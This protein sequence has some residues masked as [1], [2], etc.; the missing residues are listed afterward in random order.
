M[1]DKI[2]NIIN[3]ET[4]IGEDNLTYKKITYEI[5][6]P[7]KTY[8]KGIISGK[9]RGVKI[10]DDYEKADLFD[11]E[12]YEANVITES[13]DDFRANKSFIFPKDFENVIK[14][15]RIKGDKFPKEKLPK[16]LPVTITANEK[17][18][19]VNVLEPELFE[20]EI[21][22]KLHQTEGDEIFGSFNAYI[23]GYIIDETREIEEKVILVQDE[24][25]CIPESPSI[26]ICSNIET[27][28]T[29]TSNNYIRRE[30][31]CKNHNHNVWGNWEYLKNSQPLNFKSPNTNGNPGCASQSLGI[32]GILFGFAFLIFILPNI[33]YIIALFVIILVLGNLGSFF[34]PLFRIIG[35]LFL[36]GFI[37]SLIHSISTQSHTYNPKPLIV[38]SPREVTPYI[39]IDETRHEDQNI[40]NDSIITRYRSWKDYSGNKYEGEYKI[41]LSDYRKAHLFK[42]SLRLSTNTVNA[43]DK[44]VFDLKEFD[45][46]NF[47]SLFQLF[48]S[49][50]K[51]KKLNEIQFAEMI[52][53]FVQDIPYALVLDKDCNSNLYSD[54]FTRNYLLSNKGDC[55]GNQR[56]GINTP[57]EFLVNLKGDCDTRTLL[58]YSIL[59]HYNYDAALMSSEFYGHSIIGINL[60][61]NG[62]T[63][64]YN[65]QKY[66]L[67]ETTAPNA[68]P[69]NISNEI[70]N[71]NNWRISLKSK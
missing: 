10:D 35:I 27:G 29:E 70:S 61:I 51:A 67:W 50:G 56:F 55:N 15:K 54:R 63:Y 53:T 21:I 47:N 31:K 12:I 18:F 59:S 22:R 65:N 60:P 2:V 30:Y 4:F 33:L 11:F 52:V 16:D 5:L 48:D 24:V 6:T 25:T 71:L 57:V 49:I 14:R 17:L 64:N 34:K 40:E 37:S 69:G 19:G 45:K 3:E 7:R 26:C 32:L 23:T 66:I 9:Y 46:S 28:R 20:F 58:L 44:V 39:P 43:Y 62:T 41:K 68:K 36:I 13:R 1:L 38:D 8:L 42:E